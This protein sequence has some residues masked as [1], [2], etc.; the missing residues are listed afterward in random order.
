MSELLK[1]A[2]ATVTTCHSRTKDLESLVNQADILVV[3]I[4]QP[5]YIPGSWVK[6]GAVVIDC[7]INSISDASKKSGKSLP[8]LTFMHFNYFLLFHRL[9]TGWRRRVS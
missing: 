3:G 6:P 4:G 5:E 9:Q 1:W 7:G 2:H 8:F